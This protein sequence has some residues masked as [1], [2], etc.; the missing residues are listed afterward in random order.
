MDNNNDLKAKSFVIVLIV[1][2]IYFGGDQRA[3]MN[4]RCS[5]VLSNLPN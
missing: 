5:V 1:A 4:R 2:L 3:G